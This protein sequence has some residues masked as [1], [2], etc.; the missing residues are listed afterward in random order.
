MFAPTLMLWFYALAF[1]IASAISPDG[2]LPWRADYVSAVALAVIMAAWVTADARKR[3]QQLC[4]DYGSFVF[5]MWPIVVPIYLSQTRGAR[6][7]LTL[8]CFAG[9]WVVAML[10]ASAVFIVRD[11]VFSGP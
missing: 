4:Y 7:F 1:S 3:Q 2:M 9:I 11:F 10:A 5:F 8:L 6:A